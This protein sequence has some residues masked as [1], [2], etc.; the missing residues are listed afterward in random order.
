MEVGLRNSSG[1]IKKLHIPASVRIGV[2]GHRT[3]ANEQL[4]HESV[5][6]V[7]GKLDKMLSRTPY[8]LVV[9]SPLPEEDYLQDF[10]TQKS[11]DEFRELLAKAKSIHPPK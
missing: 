9:I 10:G 8:M 1:N 6:S 2:T 3:L 11:K 5:K 4:I 7:L